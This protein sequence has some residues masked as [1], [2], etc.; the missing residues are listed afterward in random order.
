ML[1]LLRGSSP[2]GLRGM[3]PL[4][5]GIFRP[6]LGIYRRDI[7][8]LLGNL[9]CRE[10]DINNW[11][12]NNGDGLR[13]DIMKSILDR[14]PEGY[15]TDSSNPSSDFRRNFLRN[16]ILPLLESRWEG[17]HNAFLTSL[18]LQGEAAAI[19]ERNVA[20][21]LRSERSRNGSLLSWATISNFPAPLTLIYHFGK[22]AGLS[23]ATAREIADHIPEGEVCLTPGRRWILADGNEILTTPRGIELRR[24]K[25]RS[26]LTHLPAPEDI[27][28]E[29]SEM[30]TPLMLRIKKAAPEEVYLPCPPEDYEWRTAIPGE[31]IRLFPP[32][33]KRTKLIS[34]VYGENK[35]PT[36]DRPHIAVLANRHTDETV[37]IPGLRRAGCDLI[38]PDTPRVWHWS[39]PEV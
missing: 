21:V 15:V 14:Y 4:A 31:R 22:D 9:Y 20:E 35:V 25:D 29:E 36:A 38:L 3:Y 10:W 28:I 32:Y 23:T 6:L 34:D 12:V 27:T 2:A 7:L 13:A 1:N 30:S 37:W 17:M 11:D 33:E 16:E 24:R 26:Y 18:E 19:V 5:S 8:R 39:I